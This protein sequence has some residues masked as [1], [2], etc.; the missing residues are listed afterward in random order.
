MKKGQL[1]AQL[2]TQGRTISARI[3]AALK[4]TA[5]VVDTYRLRVTHV[6]V[7]VTQRLHR[8][9]ALPELANDIVANST[10]QGQ[11]S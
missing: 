11:V 10:F 4:E 9:P 5:R 8:L 7:P 2:V 1:C 3:S 6:V